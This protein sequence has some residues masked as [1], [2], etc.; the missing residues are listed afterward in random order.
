M[1][2]T[3]HATFAISIMLSNV[4][5]VAMDKAKKEKEKVIVSYKK[6]STVDLSSRALRPVGVDSSTK[7]IV[8]KSEKESEEFRK[9]PYKH[10]YDTEFMRAFNAAADKEFWSK[11]KQFQAMYERR[12]KET[13][14][15]IPQHFHAP[16]VQNCI[17]ER[18]QTIYEKQYR[19]IF[20]G[21]TIPT[22]QAKQEA[23]NYYEN[24]KNS[25]SC[26]GN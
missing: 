2:N 9:D 11:R 23:E 3:V 14:S 8:M 22:E 21:Y 5:V 25:C 19:E 12:F 4:L 16:Y 17:I 13:M 15:S 10:K 20:P 26:F 18:I 7:P 24:K 1:K 6:L